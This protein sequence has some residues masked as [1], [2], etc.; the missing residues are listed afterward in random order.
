MQKTIALPRIHIH[1]PKRPITDQPTAVSLHMKQGLSSSE[2]SHWGLPRPRRSQGVGKADSPTHL[3]SVESRPQGIGKSDFSAHTSIANATKV[4][5]VLLRLAHPRLQ[6]DHESMPQWV[7]LQQRVK[8]ARFKIERP[9]TTIPAD[10]VPLNHVS[11]FIDVVAYPV[12]AIRRA[13]RLLK[14]HD[15]FGRRYHTQTSHARHE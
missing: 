9:A 3:L 8:I 1:G 4:P 2:H 13:I 14:P 5:L 6:G 12:A 10:K 11:M 15:D 7:I